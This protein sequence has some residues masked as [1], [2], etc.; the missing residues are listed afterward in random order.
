MEHDGPHR[1]GSGIMGEQ[2]PGVPGVERGDRPL[3]DSKGQA[4]ERV[5]Q[6]RDQVGARVNHLLAAGGWIRPGDT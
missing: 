1:A 5:R 3:E 4:L 6:I 2:L